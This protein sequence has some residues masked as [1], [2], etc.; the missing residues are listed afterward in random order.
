MG[1]RVETFRF[2]ELADEE[3]PVILRAYL[4]KWAWEVGRFFEGVDHQSPDEV[5]RGI[6]P[7]FP[8]FR[9]TESA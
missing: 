8:V 6:A 5:L 1:R 3:K 7:G 4:K 9:I 2:A